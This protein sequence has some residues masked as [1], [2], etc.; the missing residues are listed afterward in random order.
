MKPE[1]RRRGVA[2]M[3]VAEAERFARNEGAHVL[4]LGVLDRNEGARSFYASQGFGEQARILDEAS[5]GQSS[6]HR[7]LRHNVGAGRP[8]RCV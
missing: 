6:E 3:L 8:S 7:I 5:R 2:S 4:R 1:H